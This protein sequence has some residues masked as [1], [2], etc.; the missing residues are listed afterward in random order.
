MEKE[1]NTKD[2]QSLFSKPYIDKLN[3]YSQSV[4]KKIG[5]CHTHQNGYH[6]LQ[7]NNGICQEMKQQYHS[8]GN[9][10]CPFCGSMKKEEWI[11]NRT[12]ELLPT[13]YY[14][15]VFTL[16]HELNSLMLGNRKILFKALF[17]SASQTL[18]NHGNNPDFL[19]AEVGITM[20]LHT[21]GQDL[22]FHPHVH[23]IVTG[24]GFD[25]QKWIR[26]LRQN[27]KFLFPTRSLGKMYKAMFMNV[28]EQNKEIKWGDNKPES[29]LKSIKYK[30]WN[31]Y[32]K[33]PFGGPAQV[34]EYFGE[35]YT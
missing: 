19:G 18:L 21:W 28:L 29:I 2:F 24:G 35:I 1:N 32:A 11:E 26:A 4:L 10:N 6:L 22:S 15:V 31:V 25:G 3:P 30:S 27:S 16:P 17:N 34:I 8:C 13:A 12:N 14:H 33:A 7:C 23:C 20:V 5:S 9:R